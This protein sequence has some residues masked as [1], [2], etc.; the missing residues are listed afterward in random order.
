MRLLLLIALGIGLVVPCAASHARET[1]RLSP[2]SKWV[3]DYAEDSC[4]L[5]R[6]FGEGDREVTLILD[7][8]SPGDW[9]KV[10]VFGKSVA[11][12]GARPPIHGSLRFGPNEPESR[13]TGLSG[14]TGKLPT[15]LVDLAQRVAPLTEGEEKASADATRRRAQY[16]PARISADREKAAT[17]ISL[18]KALPF[19]LVLDSGP[20]DKPLA[21]LRNCSWDMVKSWGLDVEQHKTLTREVGPKNEPAKWFRSQDY[22]QEML[23][24][25]HQGIVNFRVIVDEHGTPSACRIQTSTRPKEFDDLVCKSVMKR[26][27]FEPA[28]DSQGK[29]IR[30][31][32][33]QTVHYMIGG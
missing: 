24:G 4:R 9:F 27:Q 12:R 13:I 16:Q 26:A 17:W 33:R 1:R 22:P 10:M 20:M 6:K 32:W 28:L 5:G 19:D 11:L 7:Q 25:G 31:Y 29:P 8:F 23:R 21:G 15:F 30:S 18:A 14:S 3:L 2:S